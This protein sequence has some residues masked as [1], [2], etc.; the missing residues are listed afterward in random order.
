VSRKTRKQP[1][2]FATDKDAKKLF[3]RAESIMG[4]GAFWLVCFDGMKLVYFG[5]NDG[6]YLPI[7]DAIGWVERECRTSPAYRYKGT[8]RSGIS[9]EFMLDCL[10]KAESQFQ[11]GDVSSRDD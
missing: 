7:A 11:R 4:P 9:G 10:R 5:K 8:A 1:S 3:V 2:L 6:P